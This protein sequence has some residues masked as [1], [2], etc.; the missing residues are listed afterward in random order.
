MIA[1]Q[2][3]NDDITHIK[4]ECLLECQHCHITGEQQ[5]IKGEHKEQCPKFS[6]VCPNKCEVGSVPRD[7]VEEHKK[8][9]PLEVIQCEYYV[10]G[11]KDRMA[12]K[13]QKK[14][15][16]EKMEEHLSFTTHRLINA[17]HNLTSSQVEAVKSKMN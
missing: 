4:M 6:I 9:C 7:E 8:M 14:H 3:C 15:N 17:Q 2:L 5:C 1:G 13:D 11:C 16:K 10:V 12:H